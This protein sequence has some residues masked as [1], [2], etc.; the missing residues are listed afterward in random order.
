MLLWPVILLAGFAIRLNRAQF[1]ALGLSA[2]AS[3]G[4][5]FIGY[6]VSQDADV[7]A[8]LRHPISAIGFIA[9][10]LG[11]PFTAIRT[12]LGVSAG[13]F[14]IG[15]YI[16]FL[17]VA[18]R[19]KLIG[20]TGGIVLF[21][22]Y[23]FCLLTAVAT[24]VGRMNPQDPAFGAAIAQRFIIVPLAAHAAL[25]IAAA[26]LLGRSRFHLWL[27]FLLLFILGFAFIGKSHRLDYWVDDG[28]NSMANCQLASLGFENGVDDLGL[29]R[30]VYPGPEEVRSALP[31]LRKEKL[32]S[33][34]DG[35]TDWLGKPASAIFRSISE[36]REA[37]AVNTVYPL[38]SGLMI[39]GWTDSPRKIW[40]PQRFVF[41]NEQKRIVGFGHKLPAGVP[42]GL[43]SPDTPGSL[44]W[45]GFVNL[46]FRSQSISTY[47][48]EAHG[49]ALAPIGK[50]FTPPEGQVLGPDQI[51]P[52]LKSVLWKVQGDWMKGGPVGSEPP[53]KPAGNRY[54]QSWH[55]ADTRMGQLISDPIQLPGGCVVI[56]GAH[57][58]GVD[59]LSV[60][61]VNADTGDIVVSVPLVPRDIVWRYWQIDTRD[62]A[63]VQI[64]A[65]DHGR[66]WGEW[67]MMG[68][69]HECK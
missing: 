29:M 9:A 51:G 49:K 39:I 12:M 35:R 46:S 11:M 63:R 18:I 24:A 58:P 45:V 48:V 10:Y 61:V 2:L 66:G 21:G 31:I 36:Q 26:W 62:A 43:A 59:D 64:I 20:S 7:G 40:K 42:Q 5:Y 17:I 57:G 8:L 38:E 14:E 33:F 6:Q 52:R 13:L 28:K 16:V 22:L 53:E 67:L 19:Y 55:G 47:V 27:P 50:T 23:L 15:S 25:V 37:G 4:L 44:A 56:S 3:I 30:D 1:A 65:N 54:Y 69:L 68:E 32:S 60:Q 41:L 34:A